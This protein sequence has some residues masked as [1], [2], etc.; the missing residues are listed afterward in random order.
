[1]WLHFIAIF[2]VDIE[3]CNISHLPSLKFQQDN[4]LWVNPWGL[5]HFWQNSE[6]ENNKSLAFTPNEKRMRQM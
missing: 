3:G 1:M 2:K 4:Q 6:E 5:Y